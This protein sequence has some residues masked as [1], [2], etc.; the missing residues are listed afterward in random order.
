VGAIVNLLLV[1]DDLHF[2]RALHEVLLAQQYRNTWVRD[3]LAARRFLDSE[4]F[5]LALLDIVLPGESGLDLLRWMRASGKTLPV[6]MLTARDAVTDRV[7][8]LDTG[9]DDYL[10][11]PFAMEEFL[12]RVRSLL[13]RQGEQRAATWLVG[14]LSIDTIQR[15]V[16]R[17]GISILL[18]PREFALLLA[19]AA[20]PGKVM[21]RAELARGSEAQSPE[22]GNAVDVQ[23]HSLRKKLGPHSIGTL[24][25]V[26]YFL[27]QTTP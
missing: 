23:I 27:E 5:D 22:E 9:A 6:M 25:G 26:G 15:R 17:N 21:T 1:E 4:T 2:G 19:L 12:S 18:T 11:K 14:D 20:R 7:L 8:G 13:R 16:S 24:R 3:A 10:P